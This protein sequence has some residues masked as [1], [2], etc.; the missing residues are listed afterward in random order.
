VGLLIED[1]QKRIADRGITLE[2]TQAAKEAI[3]KSGYD[4]VYGA[5]P[6]KRY[7]QRELETKV[8]RS[9]IA[10]E[11]APGSTIKVDAKDDTLTI[12][13]VTGTPSEEKVVSMKRK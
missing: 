11:I 3:A 4:A 6:L 8:A 9:L 2:V 5:R 7:I 12:V 1:V 13:P 10:D